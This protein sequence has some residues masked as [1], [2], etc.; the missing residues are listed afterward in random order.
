MQP[1]SMI[2]LGIVALVVLFAKGYIP[3]PSFGRKGAGPD[4]E[5]LGLQF[6]GAIKAEVE[7]EVA[8]NFAAKMK[9]EAKAKLSAPFGVTPEATEPPPAK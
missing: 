9:E 8:K 1:T 5:Q 2:L 7:A 3:L 6:L 4:A